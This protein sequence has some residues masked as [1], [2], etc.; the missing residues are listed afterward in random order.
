[1]YHPWNGCFAGTLS[2][3]CFF[4][5]TFCSL[6][7]VFPLQTHPAHL[8]SLGCPHPHPQTHRLEPAFARWRRRDEGKCNLRSTSTVSD[9]VNTGFPQTLK[10]PALHPESHASPI[11]PW[12]SPR[13]G[14]VSL[15]VFTQLLPP[16]ELP[17][18]A[19]RLSSHPNSSAS[20]HQRL[21]GL[22]DSSL[23]AQGHRMLQG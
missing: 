22:Q 17:L 9:P 8:G 3:S 1:M 20:S 15:E 19:L 7:F 5:P 23:R 16:P 18:P 21:E 6:G 4:V 14:N 12:P 10:D 13:P 11:H 2:S